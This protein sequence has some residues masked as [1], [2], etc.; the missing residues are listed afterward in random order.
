MWTLN[1]MVTKKHTKSSILNYIYINMP[2]KFAWD[3]CFLSEVGRVELTQRGRARWVSGIYRILITRDRME[4]TFLYGE[5]RLKNE[6][7][8]RSSKPLKR[9][10]TRT[11]R[12][13]IYEAAKTL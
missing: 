1:R 5:L 3:C 12:Y 9:L 6:D 4:T 11:I 2:P 10:L 7:I 8:V 13:K